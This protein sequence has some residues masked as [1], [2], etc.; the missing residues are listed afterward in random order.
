MEELC[1]E[2]RCCSLRG[3]CLRNP[4][5]QGSLAPP[6]H[7]ISSIPAACAIAGWRHRSTTP[8]HQHTTTALC[9]PARARLPRD[10]KAVLPTR[11]L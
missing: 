3:L 2:E 8:V 11:D 1:A 9:L 6:G 7:W 4:L 5:Q 10:T